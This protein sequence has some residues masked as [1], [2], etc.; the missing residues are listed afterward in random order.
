MLRGGFFQF[1]FHFDFLILIVIGQGAPDALRDIAGANFS[2]LSQA[3][4]IQVYI[5]PLAVF[6]YRRAVGG[7]LLLVSHDSTMV[8]AWPSVLSTS[9]PMVS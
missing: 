3:G 8:T 5:N 7:A 1:K 2:G 4:G 6:H 9:N